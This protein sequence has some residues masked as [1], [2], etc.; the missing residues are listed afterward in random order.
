MPARSCWAARPTL[1]R[2][3]QPGAALPLVG[4]AVT[5]TGVFVAR[6]QPAGPVQRG[7]YALDES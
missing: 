7:S 1:F 2:E 6:Y 3:G 5:S 4:S